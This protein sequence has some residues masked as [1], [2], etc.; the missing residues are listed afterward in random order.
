[1]HVRKQAEGYSLNRPTIGMGIATTF[2]VAQPCSARYCA[3]YS[4]RRNGTANTLN[5]GLEFL[6]LC[7]YTPGMTN[8]YPR[9]QY[10]NVW[11]TSQ[12]DIA[13][14][15]SKLL[16][17]LRVTLRNNTRTTAR[18]TFSK[19]I[20]RFSEIFLR[21][22]RISFLRNVPQTTTRSVFCVSQNRS[23][24]LKTTPH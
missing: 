3:R 9:T 7:K 15:T 14:A 6:E 12:A 1:M 5:I 11:A 8:V 23:A 17:Q 4:R 20:P 24:T 18:E 19:N 10:F 13:S 16:A 21:R 22:K 2:D